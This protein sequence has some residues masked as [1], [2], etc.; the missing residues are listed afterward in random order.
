[1]S[2]DDATPMDPDPFAELL[3]MEITEM[4][5]GHAKGR[6]ELRPELSS[7]PE[8]TIAHGGVPYALADHTGGAAAVSLHGWPTPTIDMR[9]DY[10]NPVTDDLYAEADV[11]REGRNV[12][13]VA[14]ELTTRD[15]G[16][17]AVGRGVYKTGETSGENPWIEE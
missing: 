5:D 14:V 2:T 9:V 15:D 16:T 17:V 3:G 12:A 7:T 4:Q 10:L 13:T 1:M 11:L 8:T 6:L